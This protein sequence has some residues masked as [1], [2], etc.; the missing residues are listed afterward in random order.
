LFKF[1]H[2]FIADHIVYQSQF[3]KNWWDKAAWKSVEK[4]S[5]IHNGIDLSEFTLPK[6]TE[7]PTVICLEGY[8]DYT[9]FAVEMINDLAQRLGKMGISFKV[10][11]RIKSDYERKKLSKNVDFCGSLSLKELPSVY[12]NSIYISLDINAACPNTVVEAL[13][14]GAPV[15]GFDTGA[16]KELIKD[17]GGKVVHYGSDQWKVNY[18]GGEEITDTIRNIYDNY[19]SFSCAARILAETEYSIETMVHKYIDVLEGCIN[20]R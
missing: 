10:Y 1:I 2:A 4:F 3:V 19:S 5:I 9:P 15:V 11:G 17:Q 14:C 20:K 8:L 18:P 7:K 12:K 6:F 16:L 13:G